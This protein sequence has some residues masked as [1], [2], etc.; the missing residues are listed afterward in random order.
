MF[1]SST[2]FSFTE[3]DLNQRFNFTLP[4]KNQTNLEDKRTICSNRKR[5]TVPSRGIISGNGNKSINKSRGGTKTAQC[6]SSVI[7]S[8]YD[9]SIY[10][11]KM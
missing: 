3:S 9:L 5:I 10:L 1:N 8:M 6:Q 2:P 7:V 11:L 4:S